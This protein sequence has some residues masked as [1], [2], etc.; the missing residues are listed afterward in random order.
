MPFVST[1]GAE[2]ISAPEAIVRGIAPDGGLYAPLSLPHLT[3][4]DFTRLASMD[5]AA[6]AAWTLALLLDGFSEEELVPMAKAAYAR[7]DDPEVAPVKELQGG[8]HVLELFHGPT[9]AFKDM[10]LQM[11]PWLMTASAQKQG[12]NREIAIL[13]ATSGDTGKAALEGFMDVPGTSVTVFYPLGGVSAVQEKQMV[14]SQGKNVHVVAVHGNFDDAQTGV[15]TLFG[16]PAF[17]E[18]MN[19]MGKTL[20]SANSINLGRLAPQVAY[21]LSACADL[22]ARDEITWDEGLNVC[23]PTGNFGNILAAWYAKR[24]GAP[25][26]KLICASNKNDVLSDFIR[27]GVY[28]RRRDFHKTISPSMDI[29]IS[30][31]LE[32]F[33][34]ELTDGNCARV[35]SWMH[36]L[37]EDGVYDIG[38]E[39]LKKLQKI[40]YG[41]YA[42]D[43]RT[44][45]TIRKAWEEEKY[46]LDPHTAVAACVA[47]DYRLDTGDQA[48]ML[49]VS[50]ASPYKFASDVADA[51]QVKVEGDAFE[52]AHALEAATG[53]KAP[54]QVAELKNMPVLHTRVCD[55][56]KMGKAVLAGFVK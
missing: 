11:L 19:A 41:G 33:L 18:K 7:F 54:R 45:A 55:K 16:D 27:T 29:L 25:I 17:I 1:R 28:D 36:S 32:R 6:R 34:L 14:T 2:A 50:T 44:A 49:I 39:N 47:E 9:M 26:R 8:R 12:E 4:A 31:N 43:Q 23:V 51:L 5:Y 3:K 37:S 40:F 42:D 15:K 46:L 22:L 24:M 30:S 56:E 10:A 35:R 38:E 52:A 48:P 13:T 20:S 21:Y 53:V